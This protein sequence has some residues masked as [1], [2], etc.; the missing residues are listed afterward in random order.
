[1]NW[2]GPNVIHFGRIS[3]FG[4]DQF[5]LV[6][7]ISFCLRPNHYGQVQINLVRPKPF[8]INQNCFGHIEGQGISHLVICCLV[9]WCLVNEA[10]NQYTYLYLGKY[11]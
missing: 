10:V 4:P 5:I 6:M 11:I 2:S 7:T 9:I 3:Q 1:M 8:W